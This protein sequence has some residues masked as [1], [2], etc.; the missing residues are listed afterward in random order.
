MKNYKGYGLRLEKVWED[1]SSMQN[2]DPAYFAVYKVG[3]NGAPDTLVVGSVQKLGYHSDPKQQQL[4]WWYLDLPIA[5][6][7]LTDYAVFEVVLTGDGITVGNDGVVS[8]YESITPILEGG[9]LTLNGLLVGE[10]EAK[11]IQYTVTYAEPV[12]V[13]DNVRGFKATNSPSKLPPVRFVKTDWDGTKLSGADFS[14]GMARTWPTRSLI[15]RR[16]PPAKTA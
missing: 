13:S 1:A 12:A 10:D 5:D 8:G 14:L 4:Y 7:G 11:E 16:K 9:L 6:T 2:R 3:T 15:R